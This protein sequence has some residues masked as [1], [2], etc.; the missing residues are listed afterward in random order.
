MKESM[1]L[2]KPT[3]S[4]VRLTCRGAGNPVPEV[5]WLK[6]S[7]PVAQG[8]P[9]TTLKITDIAEE[10]SGSYTCVASNRIGQVNFTYVVQVIGK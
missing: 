2:V 4:T 5:H 10:D 8:R 1:T 7:T 3:G 6:N 9:H